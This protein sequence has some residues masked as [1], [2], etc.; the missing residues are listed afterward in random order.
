[1]YAGGHLERAAAQGGG[2]RWIGVHM[3][4]CSA[5]EDTATRTM[6]EHGTLE[7]HRHHCVLTRQRGRRVAGV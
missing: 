2:W 5:L 4:E 7:Q 1:V 3:A 6:S